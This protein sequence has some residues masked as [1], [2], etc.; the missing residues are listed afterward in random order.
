MFTQYSIFAMIIS[1]LSLRME[2]ITKL[3]NHQLQEELMIG[4]NLRRMKQK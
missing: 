1:F 4:S 3:S 2:E